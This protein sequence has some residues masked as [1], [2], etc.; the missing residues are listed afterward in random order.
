MLSDIFNVARSRN[1]A[2]QITGAM[3]I[4]DHYFVQALEGDETAVRSLFDRISSDERHTDVGLVE[5]GDLRRADVLPVVDGPGVSQ[6]KGRHT[7][8]QQQR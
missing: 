1:K 8:T 3:L 5:E 4:T 2:A 7:A 6:R